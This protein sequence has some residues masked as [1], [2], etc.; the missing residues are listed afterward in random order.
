M[1]IV[2]V[3]ASY[4][5]IVYNQI[6]ISRYPNSFNTMHHYQRKNSFEY[7]P[8]LMSVNNIYSTIQMK[9][10]AYTTIP[11]HCQQPIFYL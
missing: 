5:G 9:K 8:E 6:E 10:I 3:N 4:I 7:M 2:Q 1:K 11:F